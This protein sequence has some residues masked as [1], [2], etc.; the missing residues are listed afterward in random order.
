[1]IAD[2]VWISMLVGGFMVAQFLAWQE[3]YIKLGKKNETT[4]ELRKALELAARIIEEN[5]SQTD[6]QKPIYEAI[7]K[8]KGQDNDA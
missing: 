8:A 7:N 2:W 5:I 6:E 4:S 1:M 3:L